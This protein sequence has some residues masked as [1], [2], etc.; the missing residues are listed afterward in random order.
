MGK[1]QILLSWLLFISSTLFAQQNRAIGYLQQMLHAIEQVKTA[2]YDLV[3][4][5]RINT[6]FKESEF[7][8]KLM[9]MPYKLY[10]VSAYP[11]TGAEA[12]LIKGNNNNKALINPNRFPFINISLN[13]QSNLLRKNHH[14]TFLD[15]GFSYVEKIVK[16]YIKRD[17]LQF[18]KALRFYENME[19][20]NKEYYILEINYPDYTYVT[21]TALKGETLTD[22]ANK[23][24]VNDYKI[25]S[26]NPQIKY[27]DEVKAGQKIKVPNVFAKKI[28]L[29]LDK[30]TLLPLVQNVYD[31]M[32]LFGRYEM[33][34][35]ILNPIFEKDEFVSTFRGYRF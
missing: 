12:L 24:L 13:A 2:T 4:H 17:S 5:E 23:L 27:Y 20:N 18:Y 14:Y 19:Y 26:I 32:G 22:I 8:I 3:L 29:Y 35:F 9:V 25:L 30:T 21:Y 28:V 31:E 10:A 7:K 6:Q 15:V 16:G 34:K 11:N 1:R 33:R